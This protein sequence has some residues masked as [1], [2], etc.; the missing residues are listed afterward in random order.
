MGEERP[1]GAGADLD[2]REAVEGRGG[3]RGR[4]TGAGVR[5]GLGAA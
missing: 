1:R 5:A 2:P 3:G 4:V